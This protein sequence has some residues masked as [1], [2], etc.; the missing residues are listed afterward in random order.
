LSNIFGSFSDLPRTGFGQSADIYRFTAEAQGRKGT[1]RKVLVSLSVTLGLG[2][3]A[4]KINDGGSRP[5][6]WATGLSS[7]AFL[8]SIELVDS[9]SFPETGIYERDAPLTI[10]NSRFTLLTHNTCL[11]LGPLPARPTHDSRLT[12]TLSG[13]VSAQ[14]YT[15]VSRTLRLTT[16]NSLLTFFPIFIL[17][18]CEQ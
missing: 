14:S 9:Y 17:L 3:S 18:Y 2:A 6:L 7:N 11:V 4:V 10:H 1:L 13:T 8:Q 5:P 16:D 12:R 15:P